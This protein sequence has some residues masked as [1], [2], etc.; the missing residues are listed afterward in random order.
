MKNTGIKNKEPYI[1]IT[2]TK[3]EAQRILM[4][5]EILDALKDLMPETKLLMQMLYKFEE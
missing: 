3:K 2:I 4:D 1:E 5:L